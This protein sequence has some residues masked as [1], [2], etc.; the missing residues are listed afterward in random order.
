MA[1]R[2]PWYLEAADR[3]IEADAPAPE[4]LARQIGAWFL[5]E[6]GASLGED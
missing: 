2:E 1:R 4:E 5:G 6:P 3:V